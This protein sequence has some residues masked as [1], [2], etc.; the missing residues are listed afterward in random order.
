[1]LLSKADKEGQTYFPLQAQPSFNQY[2]N[3][4]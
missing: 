4:L 1:M 3:F 2:K